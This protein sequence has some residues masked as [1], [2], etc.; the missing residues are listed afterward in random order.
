LSFFSFVE[1]VFFIVL[2]FSPSFSILFYSYLFGSC[3]FISILPQLAW[4]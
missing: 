4:D 1:L 2:R 3:V